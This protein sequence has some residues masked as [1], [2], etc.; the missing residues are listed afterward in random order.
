MPTV[1]LLLAIVAIILGA[2]AVIEANGRNWAGW[3]VIALAAIVILE[4]VGRWQIPRSPST[5]SASPGG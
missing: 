3:G 5:R 2:V 1:T 4:R